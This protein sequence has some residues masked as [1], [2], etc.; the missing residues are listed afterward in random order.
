MV[1]QELQKIELNEYSAFIT[2]QD[3][4]MPGGGYSTGSFLP[5]LLKSGEQQWNKWIQSFGKQ[6]TEVFITFSAPRDLLAVGLKSAGDAP[7]KD[8]STFNSF[9]Y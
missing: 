6:G 7:E 2:A 4:Q 5:N 8:P 9:Y 1:E 3:Q